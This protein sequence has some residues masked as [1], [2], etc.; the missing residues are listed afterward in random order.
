MREPGVEFRFFQL[1]FLS[2]DFAVLESVKICAC[3]YSY[4]KGC[5]VL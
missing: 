4:I 2:A 5:L 1:G 3:L